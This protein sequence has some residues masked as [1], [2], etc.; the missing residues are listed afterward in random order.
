MSRSEV[1]VSADWVEENLKTPGI[2][3]VE[4]DEDTSAYAGGYIT[5]AV[6]LDSAMTRPPCPPA[7]P[8]GPGSSLDLSRGCRNR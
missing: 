4:V 3:L 6:R 7:Y 1:L 5:G 8:P 2:V